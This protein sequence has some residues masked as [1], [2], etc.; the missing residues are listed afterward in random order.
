MSSRK[1]ESYL[2]KFLQ[3]FSLPFLQTDR[4]GKI[5]DVDEPLSHSLGYEKKAVIGRL[6]DDFTTDTSFSMKPHLDKGTNPIYSGEGLHLTDAWGKKRAF[7][8]S[9]FREGENVVYISLQEL[10]PVIDT[11]RHSVKEEETWMSPEV[12]FRMDNEGR[13][14]DVL[15]VHSEDSLAFHPDDFIGKKLE[16]INFPAE[17]IRL[18]IQN[19]TLAL[20]RR[21]VREFVYSIHKR[22]G[23]E[24]KYEAKI[25]P[26]GQN[27]ILFIACDITGKLETE[28]YFRY[29][30]SRFRKL[31]D[32]IP[33]GIYRTTPEGRVLMANNTFCEMLGFSSF[34]DV[35]LLNLNQADVDTGYDR[36]GF[37]KMIEEQGSL[38]GYESRIKARDGTFRYIK[39]NAHL[40]R[41]ESGQTAYYEGTIVDITK[42]KQTQNKLRKSEL[43]KSAILNSMIELFMF[44]DTDLKIQWAS[45]TAADTLGKD[46]AEM[47]GKNCYEVWHDATRPCEHCPV[48]KAMH[49]SKP[50]QG[51]IRTADGRI[52]DMRGYPVF[53]ENGTL[54][55]ATEFGQDIT[56]QKDF[57]EKL[58]HS[59][60]LAEKANNFKSEF[61][62]NISHEIRTPLNV[63]IGF[64][65]LLDN[66]LMD[67]QYKEYLESIKASSNSIL[68][69]VDDI[70][71]ISRIEAGKFNLQYKSVNLFKI[72]KELK[73]MF[74]D[75]AMRK[76]LDLSIEV[77]ESIPRFLI[78][79]EVR[80]KQIL[81]NLLSNSIKYTVRGHVK[82]KI[83]V[84]ERRSMMGS[85]EID[86]R[87]QVED[88]GIGIPEEDFENIF[89]P[90][91]QVRKNRAR[92]KGYGLGLAITKRL[93]ELMDGFIK[94]ESELDKGTTFFVDLNQVLVQ[95]YTLGYSQESDAEQE[96]YKGKTILLVDDSDV[97]RRLV[98]E[99]LEN[100][101]IKIIEAEDGRQAVTL[102]EKFRPDLILMDILM[103]EMDGFESTRIIRDNP[104][105]EKIPVVA[106]T[107]LAMKE[108]VQKIENFNFDDYLLKPF[109]ISDLMEKIKPLLGSSKTEPAEKELK[110][111]PRT[112]VQEVDHTKLESAVS[113]L[114][115]DLMKEWEDLF[116][117]REFAGIRKFSEKIL[118]IG[119]SSGIPEIIEFGEDMFNYAKDYDVENINTCLE[120]Y[121]QFVEK[122]T[123]R[124]GNDHERT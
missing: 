5:I 75:R 85:E 23:S 89:E 124:K 78:M 24:K 10:E 46:P 109:H 112:V 108:D 67:P 96:D 45:K 66:S 110:G 40:V 38:A 52:W 105:L 107:A 88:T 6:F 97:N 33:V 93:V 111:F 62:S 61:L 83:Y 58:K 69:L 101:G 53:D 92:G 68:R 7:K 55:G 3:D 15:Y 73:Q 118:S 12:I 37:I 123:Q 100:A 19:I 81:T 82:L 14:L 50:Q 27:E 70:L 121:P 94:I 41:D 9:L 39:E 60:E 51:E 4:N 99:N 84:L 120:V 13:F 113:Y 21:E 32:D 87:M 18:G 71:D 26:V 20:D 8:Y 106:L 79:D 31:Y 95:S 80:V 49:T 2:K 29:S 115:K 103:P 48:K 28:K 11:G 17:S 36:E 76:Q 25:I 54:I 72:V 56:V 91:T 1:S 16:E 35:P 90:F 98:R 47:I 77:D 30:E 65:D 22:S 64:T 74:L 44:Y 117:N 63:I 42:L 116:I 43:E 57:E 102:A 122:L 86:L 119:S 59:K 34:S 114:G 104:D